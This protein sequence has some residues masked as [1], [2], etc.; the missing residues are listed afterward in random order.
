[1]K[2]VFIEGIQGTGKTT[3]MRSL[4]E[5]LDGYHMYFEGDI[6]P[7]ELAWCSYMTQEEYEEI[8]VKYP[9]LIE[10]IEKHTA[11]EEDH[12]IVEYTRILADFREFY[13]HMERYEIY[14]GRQT[15]DDFK[16]LI[17]GRFDRFDKTGNLFKGS[18]FQN[19][20]EELML[21]YCKSEEEIM[22]FYRELFYISKQKSFRLLY[23][24]S[25][26]ITSD[27]LKIKKERCDEKGVE[28]WYPLMMNYLNASPYGQRFPFMG[29][30]DMVAYFEIRMNL[31]LR[32]AKEIMG[33]YAMILPAKKYKIE[34][35][36][37]YLEGS[38]N[39]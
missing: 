35:V 1:M 38:E 26:D 37:V 22:S 39:S 20:I 15:F 11:K 14:N 6:S 17:L 33:E 8:L 30:T 31:E 13:Q 29:I 12:F 9:H 19:I 3:L 21:F 36:I 5:K 34:D 2:N 16:N 18:L 24:C 7:I 4:A 28:M 27:I 32:I 10:E 23:L 25:D